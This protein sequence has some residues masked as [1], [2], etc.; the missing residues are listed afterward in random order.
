MSHERP[1]GQ[2]S[3]ERVLIERAWE[4]HPRR[5][6][7]E[8]YQRER[9]ATGEPAWR[10][11]VEDHPDDSEWKR[12]MFQPVDP[13]DP[14]EGIRITGWPTAKLQQLLDDARALGERRD[15]PR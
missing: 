3:P 6:L 8:Q 12:A 9:N 11:I 7:L 10:L 2:R 4:T 13:D 5:Q 15:P 1:A 14:R